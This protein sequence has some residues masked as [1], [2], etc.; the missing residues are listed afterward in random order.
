[1]PAF[2]NS[3]PGSLGQSRWFNQEM[4]HHGSRQEE[5]HGDGARGI[6]PPALA[7]RIGTEQRE[8]DDDH[9]V[10]VVHP[11]DRREI[12]QATI[13]TVATSATD[14]PA[15]WNRR[16][17]PKPTPRPSRRGQAP[18][19]AL[20]PMRSRTPRIAWFAG[21]RVGPK[22][23]RILQRPTPEGEGRLGSTNQVASVTTTAVA[24][25]VAAS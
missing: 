16:A 20:G 11:R 24:T 21:A 19:D 15:T 8:D 5:P 12:R 2:C 10:V 7:Q 9:P 1:M 22:A 23:R 18:S 3:R 17:S 25:A 6:Q 14:A 13:P 4:P